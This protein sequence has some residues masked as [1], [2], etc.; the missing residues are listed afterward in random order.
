MQTLD[1]AWNSQDWDTFKERSTCRECC[2][3]ILLLMLSS[4]SSRLYWELFQKGQGFIDVKN[5]IT[6]V[7][8]SVFPN[9]IY[10]TPRSWAE[11]AFPKLIYYNK[12]PKGG[13][14]AA[15]EQPQLYSQEVRAGFRPLRS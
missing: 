1:D 5:V 6:P 10:Q 3:E 15:W 8:V 9:E 12:V 4:A 14:F 2:S 13:H 7:A 11:A